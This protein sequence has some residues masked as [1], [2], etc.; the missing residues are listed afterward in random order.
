MGNLFESTRFTKG[1]VIELTGITPTRL[2]HWSLTGIIEASGGEGIGKY[3]EY[4]FN[5]VLGIAVAWKLY[6]SEIGCALS[7]CKMVIA[8]FARTPIADIEKTLNKGQVRLEPNNHEHS[9]RMTRGGEGNPA[10][11]N[12]KDIYEDLFVKVFEMKS[13]EQYKTGRRRGLASSSNAN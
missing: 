1:D 3:R 2:A 7:Y 13:R 4:S 6:Q 11:P 10:Y 5:Q 8:A 9:L 12:V